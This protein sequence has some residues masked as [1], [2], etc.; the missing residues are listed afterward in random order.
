M[1]F[2]IAACGGIFFAF[3][4]EYVIV[5]FLTQYASF[6]VSP[7]GEKTVTDELNAFLRAHRIVN[8]EKKN[9]KSEELVCDLSVMVIGLRLRT[10]LYFSL[11]IYNLFWR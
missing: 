8:V 1:R 10:G 7:F 3:F 6:F 9:E 11:L 2:I 4:E 5:A